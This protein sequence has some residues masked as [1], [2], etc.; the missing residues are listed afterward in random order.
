MT[1]IS[2]RCGFLTVTDLN[3]FNGPA[4]T[5]NLGVRSSNLFGRA[6]FRPFRIKLRTPRLRRRHRPSRVS[7]SNR[8]AKI[9]AGWPSLQFDP[10]AAQ[11]L[12]ARR[13]HHRRTLIDRPCDRPMNADSVGSERVRT[14]PHHRASPPWWLA[15]DDPTEPSFRIGLGEESCS[16]MVLSATEQMMRRSA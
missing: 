8:K 4:Q 6:K 3:D 10:Y 7:G 1:P 5:T 12:P 11:R 15:N 14:H 13:Q 2:T 9:T 16:Q